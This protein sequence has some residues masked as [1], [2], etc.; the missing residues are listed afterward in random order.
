MADILVVGIAGGSGGGNHGGAGE[1]DAR[2]Q[3]V[4]GELDRRPHEAHGMVG[5][6]FTFGQNVIFVFKLLFLIVFGV[7]GADDIDA[8]QIFAKYAAETVGVFLTL[9][10]TGM[11]II[12]QKNDDQPHE[13]HG[14]DCELGPG[15]IVVG[16]L[17]HCPYGIG[18]SHDG[19]AQAPG[20]EVLYLGHIVGG[21]GNERGRGEAVHLCQRKGFDV[22]IDLFTQISGKGGGQFLGK[23]LGKDCAGGSRQ[24]TSKHQ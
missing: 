2:H 3:H 18:N 24:G 17:D 7:V 8:G 11:G 14:D 16:N 5:F 22:F 4:G 19:K 23:Q 10:Q 12:D 21:T 13:H 20:K 9:A 6:A 1:I 15:G